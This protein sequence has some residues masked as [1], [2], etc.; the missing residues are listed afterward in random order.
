MLP[1]T[2]LTKEQLQEVD[3][4]IFDCDGVTIEKGTEIKETENEFFMRTNTITDRMVEKINELKKY[5]TIGFSSGR[6]LMYLEKAY[7]KVIDTQTIL[8]GENGVLTLYQGTLRQNLAMNIN[9]ADRLRKLRNAIAD[10]KHKNILGFEPK[11]FL[12]TVHCTD[13]VPEIEALVPNDFYCLWNGEAYDI[14]FQGIDKGFGMNFL[15][16]YNVLAVGNGENDK[17]MLD[18]ATIGISTDRTVVESDYHTTKSFD[19][20]GEEVIDYIL[21]KL[22]EWT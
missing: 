21:K 17:P 15:P 7:R 18:R 2:E 3:I 8:Q 10:V 22:G 5:Y 20:G 1:I 19:L 4:I 14:F 13:R 12:I 16:S 11:Q 6:S 9:E